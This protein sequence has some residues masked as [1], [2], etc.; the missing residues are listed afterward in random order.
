MLADYGDVV[1]R[2]EYERLEAQHNTNNESL[3]R[4]KTDYDTLIKEHQVLLEQHKIMSGERDEFSHELG[5]MKRSATP[6]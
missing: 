3:E 4:Y 1:P 5:L 6:R 2:R